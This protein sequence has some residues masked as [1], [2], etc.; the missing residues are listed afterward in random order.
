MVGHKRA[1]AHD[2]V[3]FSG[4]VDGVVGHQELRRQRNVDYGMLMREFEA[5]ISTPDRPSKTVT[6]GVMPK[7]RW[8]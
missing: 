3:T 6:V 2:P 1:N 8:G 5:G 4:A 7:E